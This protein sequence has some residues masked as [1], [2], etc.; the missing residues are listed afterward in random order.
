M[1]KGLRSRMICIRL[2][3]F[4]LGFQAITPDAHDLSSATLFK[5]LDTSGDG[6]DSLP[7]GPNGEDDMADEVCLPGGCLVRLIV[8]RGQGDSNRPASIVIG[9]SEPSSLCRDRDILS[10]QATRIARTNYGPSLVRLTC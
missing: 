5:L 7:S 3:M 9:L 1:S 2:L 8:H 10:Y 4:T 6:V